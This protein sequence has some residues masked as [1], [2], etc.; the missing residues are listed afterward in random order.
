MLTISKDN[1]SIN[2]RPLEH[3]LH[4][5]NLESIFVNGLLSHNEAYKRGLISEDISMTEVQERRKAK[6]ITTGNL[7]SEY[8]T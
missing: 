8:T 6:R 4:H 7:N 5:K 1:K 3:M 2:I